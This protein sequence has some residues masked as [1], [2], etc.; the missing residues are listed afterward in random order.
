M[1][2]YAQ[3]RTFSATALLYFAAAFR[4]VVNRL[5]AAARHLDEWITRRRAALHMIRD[6]QAMSYRELCDVRL[7]AFDV[8]HLAW[9]GNALGRPWKNALE[10]ETAIASEAGSAGFT[11]DCDGLAHLDSHA[12]KD[13]GAPHWLMARAAEQQRRDAEQVYWDGFDG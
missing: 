2:T 7:T 4:S 6:P 11:R 8:Q 13:I 3:P 9:G 10:S 1:Y 5:H 12:L